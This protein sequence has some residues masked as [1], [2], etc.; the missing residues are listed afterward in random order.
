MVKKR[1][2]KSG[3]FSTIVIFTVIVFLI[4]AG[5]L[6]ANQL[7]PPKKAVRSVEQIRENSLVSLPGYAEECIQVDPVSRDCRAYAL[8]RKVA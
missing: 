6:V 2:D 5:Y 1:E 3:D 8:I 7:E 4:V